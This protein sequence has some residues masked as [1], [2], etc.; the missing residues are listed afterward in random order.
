[1][2]LF[3]LRCSS[4]FG[5]VISV[6]ISP[7]D[8]YIC[9][10]LIQTERLSLRQRKADAE[11]LVVRSRFNNVLGSISDEKTKDYINSLIDEKM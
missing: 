7:V 9:R 5:V 10:T 1:M 11:K 6:C 2:N 3:D 8:L 4:A